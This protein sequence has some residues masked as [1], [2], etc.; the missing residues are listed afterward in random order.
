MSI[1]FGL[2]KGLQYQYVEKFNQPESNCFYAAYNIV[3]DVE[4]F[5]QSIANID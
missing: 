5:K 1:V 2:T 3:D 4:L